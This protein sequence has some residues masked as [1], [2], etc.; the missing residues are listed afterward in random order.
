VVPGNDSP[1]RVEVLTGAVARGPFGTGSK[2]ERE[3]VWLET[4]MGRFVLR[5]KNGPTFGDRALDKYVGKRV[6]CDG[7]IVGYML[8]AERIEI[9]TERKSAAVRGK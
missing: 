5:R 4:S 2:S 8:L 6:K 9:L 3:A 1:Q 7:F